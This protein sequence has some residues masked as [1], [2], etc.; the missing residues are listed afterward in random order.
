MG[1]EA[2]DDEKLN[3][4]VRFLGYVHDV[5]GLLADC[6]ILLAPS[7]CGEGLAIV[8]MEAKLA[9]TASLAA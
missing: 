6:D 7:V 8:V 2:S 1:E 3:D 5:P 4:C 9:A